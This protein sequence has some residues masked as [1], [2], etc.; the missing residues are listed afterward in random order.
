MSVSINKNLTETKVLRDP[1]HEYIRISDEV[2]WNLIDTTE[3]QRLRRIHQLGGTYQ[4]Y[5]TAEHSRFSHSLGVYE[6][7]NRM[8]NEVSG[9]KEVLSEYEQLALKCAALLHDVGHGPFSHAF[10]E[11]SSVN[12]EIM[13]IKIILGDTQINE[14]LKRVSD[15]L[16]QDVADII[17]HQHP[18][19]L[20]TQIVSSQM[21]ADRMDYLL[22][23]SF[24]T[25]VSYGSFDLERIIR[26]LRVVDDRL[27]VKMSGINAVED[28]IMAR[29]QMYWQ[30]YYHPVS[31]AFEIMLTNTFKAIKETYLEDPSVIEKYCPFFIPFI[32]GS[33]VSVAQHLDLDEPTCYYGFKLLSKQ[34]D[35]PILADLSRRLL[36]RDL[37]KYIDYS[38]EKFEE[39]NQILLSKGIDPQ[40]YMGCDTMSQ[41]PYVPYRQ[42]KN[43]MDNAILIYRKDE[44]VVEITEVSPIVRAMAEA[45]EQFIAD[46]KIFYVWEDVHEY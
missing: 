38:D 3:F 7:T 23:D 13:S 41:V 39:L 44:S 4:V 46:R 22:R 35:H 14:V 27:V 21:D 8:I 6:I 10:E 45:E 17:S 1:I 9:L 5:H 2:I 31:R 43:N 32:D 15:K 19:K 28:Y 26:T 42:H 16:P 29:Y 34:S 36:D 20:L 25:G 40:Y 18:R 24:F 33:E 11:V 37:F 30:V 12:H